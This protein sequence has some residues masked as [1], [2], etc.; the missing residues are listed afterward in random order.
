VHLFAPYCCLDVI[1][2]VFDA[3]CA[4]IQLVGAVSGA[5]QALKGLCIHEQLHSS[6]ALCPKVATDKVIIVLH[7]FA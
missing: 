2:P 3:V 1:L 4:F 5:K 7:L 6:T